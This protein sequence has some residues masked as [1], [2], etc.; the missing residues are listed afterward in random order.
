MGN[1]TQ[2]DVAGMQNATNLRGQDMQTGLG[3]AGLGNQLNIA[4]M[5]NATNLRGQDVQAGLG[6][7]G[8]GNQL[9]IASMGNQTQRDVAGM[10][11]ATTIRGQDQ[12]Y[13]LGLGNLANQR[14]QTANQYNLGQ[15]SVGLG[16]AGLQN[17]SNIAGM[18]NATTMRGQDQSFWLGRG[19][20][21]NQIKQTENQYDLGLRSNDLGYSTLDA[22]IAQNNFGNQLAGANLGLNVYNQMQGNNQSALT[23][24]TNIQNTPM[25]Y[26]SQFANQANAIGNGYGATTGTSS[27]QGSPLM[28]ALG[29]YQL[30]GQI[31]KN[32]GIGG[33]GNFQPDSTASAFG[34]N[35]WD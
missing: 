17:Q 20:L 24:G 13:G 29:G 21:E 30:G 3:Y 10:Q 35:W 18:Q 15:Q 25:N 4:G 27:A 23:A 8:L 2:R 33:S 5:Q 11:N 14:Q 19:S 1:Q 6:Y 16:Y 31:S 26:W 7:A 22:N 32:L 12:S 9:N 28:G 34:S